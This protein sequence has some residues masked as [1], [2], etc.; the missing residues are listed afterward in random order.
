MLVENRMI[1]EPITIEPD[2]L[3]IRASHKMRSGGFRRLPVV[4]DGKLIGIISERDLREH[5]G[6]LEHIKVNGV[7]T[8]NPFTVSPQTPVEE[9]AR[10]MVERQ[11][12]GLPVVE[13]GRLIG[14]IT[15]TDVMN[16]FLDLM[17][18]SMG[19]STRID[20]VLEGEQHGLT[21]ASRIVARDGGEVMGI[22]TYRHKLGDNPVCYLRLI[23]GNP[24]KI[25]NA[26]RASGFD[27]LGVHRIGG[28]P[29]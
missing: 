6:H 3:L 11:I 28:K 25:A 1:K 9:A 22:G 5:R 10:I 21:E 12:G 7:M 26:L 14:I 8:E 17:G 23:A 18:A 13:E 27:V 16:A 2:E 4:R 15:V 19:G 20:F 24:D 29:E